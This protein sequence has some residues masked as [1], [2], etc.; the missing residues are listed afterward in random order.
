MS[1][2]RTND[3]DAFPRASLLTYFRHP[4]EPERSSRYYERPPPKYTTHASCSPHLESIPEAESEDTDA[5]VDEESQLGFWGEKT[6]CSTTSAFDCGY[7]SEKGGCDKGCRW[8][9]FDTL[10][11]VC[12]ALLVLILLLNLNVFLRRLDIGM[13]LVDRD[14]HRLISVADMGN[15]VSYCAV[16]TQGYV[17][18]DGCRCTSV[19]YHRGAMRQRPEYGATSR[20][21]LPMNAKP[22]SLL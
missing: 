14:G 4:R 5:G 6:H 18:N 10:G 8:N 9:F 15:E 19:S 16:S 22:K 13:P 11:L 2:G 21:T 12:Y 20:S 17:T 3:L 7:E 1:T